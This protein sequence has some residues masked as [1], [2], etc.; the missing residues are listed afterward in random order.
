MKWDVKLEYDMDFINVNLQTLISTHKL[1][2]TQEENLENLKLVVAF[3]RGLLYLAARVYAP[4]CVEMKAWFD[5]MFGVKYLTVLL[6]IQRLHA[7]LT[8]VLV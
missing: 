6:V 1:I 2:V 5:K 3:H 7:L 8:D 4:E